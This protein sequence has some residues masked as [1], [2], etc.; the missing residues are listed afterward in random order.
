MRSAQKESRDYLTEDVLPGLQGAIKALTMLPKKPRNPYLWLADYLEK[1]DPL[2]PPAPVDGYNEGGVGPILNPSDVLRAEPVNHVLDTPE[3]IQGVTNFRRSKKHPRIYG[4]HQPSVPGVKA[5]V[6]QLCAEHGRLIWICV[7]DDP[8][9]YVNGQPFNM[10][11]KG[12]TEQAL[13]IKKACVNTGSELARLERQLVRDLVVKASTAGGQLQL[14]PAPSDKEDSS[15]EP[16]PTQIPQEGITTFQ[17]VFDA[18]EAEGFGVKLHRCLFCKDGAPEPEEI[19][20]LVKAVRE[21]GDKA[22]IVMSCSSGVER[23]QV[24]IFLQA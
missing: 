4:V 1:N 6:E 19:D 18:M 11:S 21:A 8:V 24:A 3:D 9:V 17:G 5:L 23:T 13:G 10:H 7:R 15:A 20:E 2:A 16:A 14:F 22:A 12:S